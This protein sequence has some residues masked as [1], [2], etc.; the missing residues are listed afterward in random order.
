MSMGAVEVLVFACE[1]LDLLVAERVEMAMLASGEFRCPCEQIENSPFA[2]P[3]LISLENGGGKTTT[4]E[5][6]VSHTN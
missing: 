3:V 5:L 2:R 1:P 6:H 4:I